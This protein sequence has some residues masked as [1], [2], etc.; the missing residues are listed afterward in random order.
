MKKV[1]VIIIGAGLVGSMTARHLRKHKL[2]VLVID[3]NDP[4]SASKCSGGLWKQGWIN[5]IKDEAEI[6][7]GIISRYFPIQEK[8][9]TNDKGEE[10][11]FNYINCNE[12]VLKPDVLGSVNRIQNLS[13]EVIGSKSQS[14]GTY[15]ATKAIIICAGVYTN[16][17]LSKVGFKPKTD[18]D[19]VW[20]KVL[21]CEGQISE[22]KISV[23]A[24]YRQ[25]T[26]F[27]REGFHYFGDGCTV[28]NPKPEDKRIEFATE[29]L[30]EHAYNLGCELG[31]DIV[32]K[33]GLRPYIQKG[34]SIVNEYG[35]GIYAA[36]GTA[37][38]GTVLCG[39][40][41]DTLLKKIKSL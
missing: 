39:Y 1:E 23:W 38:N 28:K 32:M 40:I 19:A 7:E 24:P 22:N 9:L 36:V 2:D 14:I 30:I 27:N 25:S 15:T 8:K 26:L 31:G 3:N 33:E 13:V 29:R 41:A 12:V 34:Q 18:V 20:G 35:N 21:E 10:E 4:L 5:G 6:G 37:K 17:L 11:V 16:T